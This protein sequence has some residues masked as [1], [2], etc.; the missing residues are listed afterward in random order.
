[1]ISYQHGDL[2]AADTEAL[3]NTVNC[4][5]VMGKG[6]ALDFKK[7]FPKNFKQYAEAC[8]Q[9]NVKPGRMFITEQP[10]QPRYIIN[11]PTKR[12][13]R[14][15]SRM[16]DV[17]AGLDAFADEVQRRNIRSVA[18][19]ALG[20]GNGGLGWDDVQKLI[21]QRLETLADGVRV[22]VFPPPGVQHVPLQEDAALTPGRAV[23]VAL[24]D[25]YLAKQLPR[26]EGAP[27]AAIHPMLYLAQAAG[28]QLNLDF[29]ESDD[30]CL[31]S[32]QLRR[33]L[34]HMTPSVLS[35][36][37]PESDHADARLRPVP[38]AAERA[39]ST[40]DNTPQT[41]AHV[42]RVM[43]LIDGFETQAALN[44]LAVCHWLAQPQPI[45]AD[46]LRHHLRERGFYSKQIDQARNVLAQQGWIHMDASGIRSTSDRATLVRERKPS[47][48]T[49]ER[50][51]A[52][53]VTT[54][55]DT[56][57]LDLNEATAEEL[58]QLPKIGTNRA[59]SIVEHRVAQG[60]FQRS[61]DLVHV[62]GIGPDLYRTL[63]HRI[64]VR[65]LF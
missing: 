16:A 15:K 22:V 40:M 13:W 1:M 43:D 34:R 8:K 31:R 28:E 59:R 48:A 54:T 25:H 53:E 19:P 42:R 3:V 29:S 49:I 37:G 32:S 63:A 12:H 64:T 20:C 41:A 51:A 56:A 45:A 18:M 35:R 2:L 57:P 52:E 62:K 30:G 4:V 23:L 55:M 60:T 46:S 58:A 5:G 26:P 7:A 17:E 44:L 14:S 50:D 6:I 65:G 21:E 24:V 9:G 61:Q 38:D 33:A 11:F 10:G 47:R 27:E 36:C 39:A